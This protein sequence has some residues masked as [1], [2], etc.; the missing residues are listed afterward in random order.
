MGYMGTFTITLD[1][2]SLVITYDLAL[3]DVYVFA[4]WH[5]DDLIVWFIVY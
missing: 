5:I 1:Y 3:R 2:A 4:A